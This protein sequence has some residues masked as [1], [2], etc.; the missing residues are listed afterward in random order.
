MNKGVSD[1]LVLSLENVEATEKLGAVLADVIPEGVLV[2]LTGELGTG[3]TTLVRGVLRALGYQGAVKSPTY[4]LLEE[5]SLA[6]REII[7]FDL[8]RLIDPEELDLI[9][10]RDYFNGKTRCFVEWPDRGR[11]HLPPE[12]LVIRISHRASGRE[13]RIS[14]ASDSGREIIGSIQ[15]A[16]CQESG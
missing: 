5:Y 1:E 4:T 16:L 3:K 7:H 6:G 9:G 10:I 2:F 12:D 13:A 14:A 8:Y 11:G 15:T